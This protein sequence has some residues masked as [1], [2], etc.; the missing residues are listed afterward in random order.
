MDDRDIKTCLKNGP[1]I[2]KRAYF[3]GSEFVTDY[4]Q[5]NFEEAV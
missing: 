5:K 1:K 3:K 4:V 2:F